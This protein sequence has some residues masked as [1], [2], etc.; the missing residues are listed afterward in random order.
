MQ[1]QTLK[2]HREGLFYFDNDFLFLD[3]N[4][5]INVRNRKDLENKFKNIDLIC[6]K[7]VQLAILQVIEFSFS[8]SEKETISEALALLGF[9]RTTAKTSDKIISNIE[10]LIFQEKIII[11]NEKLMLRG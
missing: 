11:D 7:E 2:T 8:I 3:K 5:E 4:K 1:V 9:N 10:Y 6:D